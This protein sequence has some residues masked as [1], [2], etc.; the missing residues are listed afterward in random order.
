[1]DKRTRLIMLSVSVFLIA[2]AFIV[3][4][5][6]SGTPVKASSDET[7]SET[8]TE[9]PRSGSC[10]GDVYGMIYQYDSSGK[11]VPI[12]CEVGYTNIGGQCI[13]DGSDTSNLVLNNTSYTR[14]G[15]VGW[16][17]GKMRF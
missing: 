17:L 2:T 16:R 6:L 15:R 4:F 3:W 12:R 13:F 1:M 9:V 14:A 10:R 11:C 5:L 7:P 8:P